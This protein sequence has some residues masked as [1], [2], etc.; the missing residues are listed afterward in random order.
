MTRLI[1]GANVLAD[2]AAE[3]VGSDQWSQLAR[4]RALQLDGE[5]RNAATCI[6]LIRPHERACRTR[7]E[8][9]G[10]SAATRSDSLC[11]RRQLQVEEQ[12]AEQHETAGAGHD[13]QRRLRLE[14][15]PR[16]YCQ[17]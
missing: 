17:I 9:A 5:V 13:G 7:R 14:A 15:E 8:A 10:A 12:L 16:P 2:V 4:D 1:P 3:D 11:R 6:E